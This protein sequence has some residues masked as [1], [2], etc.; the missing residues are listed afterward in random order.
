MVSRKLWHSTRVL[1]RFALVSALACDDPRESPT[2]K[3]L[4]QFPTHFRAL[5]RTYLTNSREH[6][7]RVRAHTA[8]TEDKNR[9]AEIAAALRYKEKSTGSQA[10]ARPP[11]TPRMLGTRDHRA[12]EFCAQFSAPARSKHTALRIRRACTDWGLYAHAAGS[13]PENFLRSKQP[14]TT[15][16]GAPTRSQTTFGGTK[17]SVRCEMSEPASASRRPQD[18][19]LCC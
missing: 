19:Q 13:A 4:K 18:L 6:P 8:S 10:R 17:A 7:R 14:S 3:S 12:R 15:T 16:R 5:W 11:S 9:S 1:P 2:R